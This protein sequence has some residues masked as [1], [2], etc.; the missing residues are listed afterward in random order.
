MAANGVGDKSA[1]AGPEKGGKAQAP[2][3]DAVRRRLDLQ[4]G[5]SNCGESGLNSIARMPGGAR[6]TVRRDSR[7]QWHLRQDFVPESIWC[8]GMKR[9]G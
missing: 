4:I 6:A 3:R 7:S 5:Q 2:E 8:N 9:L 1:R